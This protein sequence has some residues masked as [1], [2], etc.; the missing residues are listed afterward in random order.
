MRG[1][2]GQHFDKLHVLGIIPAYAGNTRGVACHDARRWDHPRVCGEHRYAVR[3]RT[4][5]GGSSPRMRGTRYDF[6]VQFRS[7]GI[8]PAYAGNTSINALFC[9]A[10]RDHPRVCGEHPVE[11]DSGGVC[12]GSSP[13]MRGTLRTTTIL[14]LPAGIIPAYAGNTRFCPSLSTHSRD[15]PRVCGEH[16]CELP[17]DWRDTGSSPRMRGTLSALPSMPV[18]AG[19]IPAYAGNTLTVHLDRQRG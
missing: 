8:I 11:H 12:L 9:A 15:H 7:I 1:T 17:R 13:R 18:R 16:F 3:F 10:D 2:H 14:I 6:F 5:V 19:I 4:S